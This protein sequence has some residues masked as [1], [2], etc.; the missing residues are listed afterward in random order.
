MAEGRGASNQGH[1]S[2]CYLFPGKNMWRTSTGCRGDNQDLPGRKQESKQQE[3]R[4]PR[5]PRDPMAN[6]SPKEAWISKVQKQKS[7]CCSLPTILSASPLPHCHQ[8]AASWTRHSGACNCSWQYLVPAC[9]P[10]RL[11]L[12]VPLHWVLFKYS[13]SL[14][15]RETVKK[16][17]NV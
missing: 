3:P 7:H 10:A 4:D 9:V 16:G 15:E 2:W 8:K 13:P 5:D 6:A 1:W 17:K 14:A 12:C 11:Q